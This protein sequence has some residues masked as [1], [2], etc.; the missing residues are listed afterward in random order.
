M[1]LEELPFE[2]VNGRT[3][4]GQ[5][6]IAIAHPEHS[7]VELM[8]LLFFRENKIRHYIGAKQTVH[9]KSQYLF[10]LKNNEKHIS[11]LLN[12]FNRI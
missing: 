4:D 9:M 7:S 5:K 11:K 2:S 6:V 8:T 1:A 12:R 10:S 3:D